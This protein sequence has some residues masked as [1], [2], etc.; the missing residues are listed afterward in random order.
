MKSV[1]CAIYTRKSSEDGLEQDFNSLDAQREACGAYVLSQASEGWTLLPDKYDDGGLSGGTLERP[2]LQRLLANVA[3]G[4][5][6]IIVIYKLDRLTRSLL[7]FAKLVEALDQAGTSFVSVTQS[8][9]TTTS[10]GRLTLNMLLSFA[11]FEREV[12]AERIRDKIAASK[13]KGMW[14]GGI[15]PLGYKPHGR[16]LV[17]VEEHAA[18]VRGIFERY[19]ELGNVRLVAES[20]KSEGRHCPRRKT[21]SGKAYGGGPFRRGQLYAI[22]RNPIYIGRILHRGEQHQGQHSAIINLALWKAVQ[23]RLTG[24]VKGTRGG[25][26]RTVSTLA[27]RIVDA[28]G[29][30]LIAVHTRKG[31]RRYRYYVSKALHHDGQSATKNPMRIPA[32]EIEQVV[33]QECARLLNDPLQLVE[34]ANLSSEPQ[35]LEGLMERSKTLAKELVE[36]QHRLLTSIIH[37]VRVEATGLRIEILVPSLAAAVG[38]TASDVSQPLIERDCAVRLART[39]RALRLID[40]NGAAATEEGVDLTL[41]RL[42]VKARTWWQ[43]I[44]ETG[45]DP[46]NLAALESVSRSYI[47]RVL[48]LAFLSP[49]VVEAVLDGRLRAGIDSSALLNI[50]AIDPSWETQERRCMLRK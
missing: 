17:V 48:R 9:N 42:I 31:K 16:T 36:G 5:V 12:T 35:E 7:D 8:F 27:G 41:L 40:D 2:A 38:L 45:I 49:A 21:S 46:S 29:A 32:G 22:L 37:E 23:G 3:A 43:R 39:G 34:R 6:D 47:V 30:P 25:R 26:S 4:K 18:L 50:R 19:R 15:P 44:V 1:R 24:N 10:M 33:A 14:M 11:Q 13:A 20:L 28:S